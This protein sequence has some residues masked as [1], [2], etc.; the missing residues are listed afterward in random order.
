MGETI[1]MEINWN[2]VALAAGLLF[3][4]MLAAMTM[5]RSLE[6]AWG[7]LRAL[8]RFVQTLLVAM[9]VVATV[10]A[11]KPGNG[12]GTNE[13]PANVPGPGGLTAGHRPGISQPSDLRIA[14]RLNAVRPSD[15]HL[16]GVGE[17]EPTVTAEEIAQGHRLVS[18]TNET[19]HSFAMPTNA[20]YIGRLH[21]HGA[22][23]DFGKH[24]V[25][26]DAIGGEATGWAFPYG[27]SNATTSAF[28]WFMDGRLQDALCG[29][30]FVASAGLG[31]TLAMQGESRLWAHAG[32]D[33][34]TVTW[35]RFF[36]GG[37]TNEAVNAQIV[38]DASGNFTV[39]SNDL[40]R[41]FRRID[42]N[43]W[44]GDGL[45]NL[46]DEWPTASD[47]DCFGTGLDWL[48]ANCRGVLSA[49]P[50]AD[51]GYEIVWNAN[52]N[53]NA[54]FWLAFTPTHDGTRVTIVCDGPSNLGDMVVL[55][56]EGQVCEV[57]MLM[58]AR[59]HVTASWPVEDI[60]ASD[61]EAEIVDRS[62]AVRPSNLP[63]PGLRLLV[64]GGG[65]GPS[66]DFEV[67]R[68]ID[69]DLEGDESGGHITSSPDIGV[70]IGAVTG[71]C[72]AVEC[73]GSNY[74]WNCCASCHCTGYS[75]WWQVTAL[76]EGYSR[77]FNWESQCGCQRVNETNTS[78]WVSI[79]APR[80]IIRGGN[81]HIVS[82]VYDPP[83]SSNA[84]ASM[85]LE[86][87]AGADK[88]TV[89]SQG[90]GWM[91][92]KGAVLSD[93][94]DD[95]EFRLVSEIG[96]QAYTNTA[97]LTVACVTNL[98]MTCAFAGT[99]PTPPPFD[100]ET[101]CPFSITNSLAPDR[102]LVVPFSNVAALG[103]SGFVVTNF[104]VD[105]NL[106]LAPAGVNGSSL[107]CDWEVVEAKPEMNGA[108]S[109]EGGLTAH[110]VNPKQGGV[111]RFRGRCDGS[112]WTEG[113][114]VLPL[115]G[116]SIDDV[117]ASDMVDVDATIAHLLSHYTYLERQTISFGEE[118]F[119]DNGVGDYL[120]RVDS[121]LAPTVWHYNQ[122]NDLSG[123]G[124]VA[125]F[126]G[127]PMRVTKLSNFL[128][129]YETERINV[130]ALSRW[131]ARYRYGTWDDDAGSASW[132]AGTAVADGADLDETMQAM[133][134]NVWAG[135][136]VKERRLWPNSMST[137]NHTIFTPDI[138]FNFNFISPGFTTQRVGDG[139]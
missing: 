32:E 121:A 126:R 72:C 136:D 48:N 78:A 60:A 25:D 134:T 111:Y 89:L 133:A 28:W 41:V 91:E 22:R 29:P 14:E 109:H 26:L 13:P 73:T 66:D 90:S 38:L 83:G 95:V 31:D 108:L 30:A 63:P 23:S 115:S 21:L 123:M 98:D 85:S 132:D 124:A 24:I 84:E 40:L 57:P 97:N 59:Y 69:I 75:Q 88:I 93:S 19:G 87:T 11:Q 135:A 127:V 12:G 4:G 53:E 64:G 117:F 125:T 65:I 74:V 120:G 118:W 105:M 96:G 102:H 7:Q 17:A 119:N 42:P 62:D 61:P 82:G 112:P 94:I 51:D 6:A 34:R 76:W 113:N 71:N 49:V 122:V 18:V 15:L 101:A 79:S 116:A 47:G 110:F 36:A 46:I 92:V 67:E 37:D 2:L 106:V 80:V 33:T 5:R 129:A 16:L 43:D 1:S 44:D 137:D 107:P 39:R 138:D 131:L 54:Y 128:V 45:D 114:V 56:N 103:D 55:A 20:V 100:G 27:P 104:T 99:S 9:A 70:A 68:P 35:E 130:F 77:L 3:Y 52:A 50:D 10:E 8:P 139:H 58:G 86:C 81:S